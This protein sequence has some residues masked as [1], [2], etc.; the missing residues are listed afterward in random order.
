MTLPD[1]LPNL[2]RALVSIKC[3]ALEL[4]LERDPSMV[5][6]VFFGAFVASV[7]LAVCMFVPCFAA[8]VSLADDTFTLRVAP[9]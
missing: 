7:V 3:R 8:S 1:N 6:D 2:R 4:A 9:E 5:H